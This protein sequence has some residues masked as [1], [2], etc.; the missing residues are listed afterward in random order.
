MAETLQVLDTEYSADSV[1]WCP[2]EG[3]QEVLLCGT[4][5]LDQSNDAQVCS[6]FLYLFRIQKRL[7]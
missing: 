3:Y 6:S 7:V 5:Q 2:H 1:E 4:Y